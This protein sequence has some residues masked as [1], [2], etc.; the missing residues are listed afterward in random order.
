MSLFVLLAVSLLA[1]DAVVHVS[2][3]QPVSNQV[4]VSFFHLIRCHVS[5][6]PCIIFI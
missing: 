2:A 3:Q 4:Q 1:Y 6:S 5:V